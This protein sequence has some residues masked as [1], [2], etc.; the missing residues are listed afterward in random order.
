MGRRKHA[1]TVALM[2]TALAR[3]RAFAI[4]AGTFRRIALANALMLLVIV[5][6]GATVRLTASGPR[7]PELAGL[8]GR[9]EAARARPLPADR[10]LEPPHFRHHDPADARRRG[11]RHAGRRPCRAWTRRV[12]LATFLGALAQAP[13]GAITV[14]F[15]LHPLL[16]LIALPALGRRSLMLGVI[17]AL[18]AWNVRGEALPRRPPA[19][20]PARRHLVRRCSSSRAR[21]RRPRARSP[22]AS[23]SEPIQR[24]R[25][26]LRLD[27]ACTSA[28]RPCSASR[29][30]CSRSWLGAAASRDL[31][32]A[33]P[34]FARARGADGRRRDP[35]P[36]R[37]ALVD[38]AHPRHARDGALGRDRRLRRRALATARRK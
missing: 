22:A 21:S 2:A 15:D 14:Y 3:V 1:A 24:S 26:L 38:R 10:V 5:S 6:S 32:C 30:S 25:G 29:S 8:R 13:L 11:S 7:L 16:V 27:V 31:R 34:I 19:A 12:A 36:D 23:T 28:R 9:D 17:V 18:E 33:I 20:R 4:S 35:V 37:H